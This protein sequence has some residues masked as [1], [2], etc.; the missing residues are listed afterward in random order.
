MIGF[1]FPIWAVLLI[2]FAILAVVSFLYFKNLKTQSLRLRIALVSLRAAYTLALL[3]IIFDATIT[4]ARQERSRLLITTS[5]LPLMRLPNASGSDRAEAFSR[6]LSNDARLT[7]RFTIHRTIGSALTRAALVEDDQNSIPVSAIVYLADR[8]DAAIREAE[9]LSQFTVA[10]LFI[11][12]VSSDAE[13]PD[14]NVSSVDCGGSALLDVPQMITATLYGR[15]MAGRST[16]VKLSDEAVVIFATVINWKE[17]SESITV[18]LL[19]APRVEGLHRYAVKAEP[20]EGELNTE[21]N[22]ASFSLDV[23]RGERKILFIENQPT[24]EGK[25]IRRALEENASI[26]VDYFAEVS[27]DAVLNQQ[28]SGIERNVHSILGDFKQLARYDCVIAGPMDASMISE[29]EAQNI[30]QFVERRGGGFVILGSNDFN[31]SILSASSRL[32]NLCPA[33]VNINAHSNN[34]QQESIAPL[35][36]E[37]TV[38]AKTFLAP[39]REGESLFWSYANDI[40]IS[41]LGPLSDSYLRVKSLKP[42][43]VTL[44]VVNTEKQALITAQPYGYG[45]TL[46]FAPADSWRIQLAESGENKGHFAALWQNIAFWAAGNAEDRD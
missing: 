38:A 36:V 16:L 9:R 27:R 19:L 24:W 33:T 30:N 3:L 2:C 44:A 20:V 25:F 23:R 45:R 22:E 5:D 6:S 13:L 26:T 1:G 14:I 41:N 37:N 31:G 12:P 46:L 15:R 34:S 21:N 32:A 11:V 42:G 8:S 17:N 39:T 4:L 35:A 10:P 29:R 7:E 18:P 43:A 28:Q 40:L